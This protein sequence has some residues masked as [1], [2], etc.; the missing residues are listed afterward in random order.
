MPQRSTAFEAQLH[1]DGIIR[2]SWQQGHH[3]LECDALAL[4]EAVSALSP[5]PGRV[6]GM[7][8]DMCAPASVSAPARKILR[9]AAFAPR[10]ALLGAGPMDL[11][12]AAFALTSP[13]PTRFFL[14]E[15]DART[16]LLAEGA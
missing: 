8:V 4:I 13:T 9:S 10:V 1:D 11:V 15:D 3:L 5:E 12:L 2:V 16:W 7:L 6:R 14:T